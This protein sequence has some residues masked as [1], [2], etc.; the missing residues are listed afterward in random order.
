MQRML[1]TVAVIALVLASLAV[2]ALAAHWPF[3][4]RAWQWQQAAEGWPALA[5]P[6]HTLQPAAAP[7]ALRLAADARLAPP[8]GDAATRMVLV[9]DVGGRAAYW[10]APGYDVHALVD[11]RDLAPSVLAP[12]FGALE[13]RHSTPSLDAPLRVLLEQ[14]AEDPRGDITP[15]QLLW[16]M[17][18]LDAGQL[19]PL[20][21]FS[22]RAQLASGPDF[23]RAALDTPLAWPPG[24]HFEP[25]PA[26]A[27]LLSIAAG[28]LD[29]AGYAH[30]LQQH[31]WGRFAEHPAVGLLDHRR[32]NLAA[33]CCLQAAPVDWLRLGL[34]LAADGRVGADRILPE[35]YVAQMTIASP[36]HPAYGLGYRLAETSGVV[37]LSTGTSGRR[38]AIALQTGRAA[39]WVGEGEP[40][41]WFEALLSPGIFGIADNGPGG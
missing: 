1:V 21:P 13:Q 39:L 11:A 41:A 12:L 36:V 20:N 35:G 7:L 29:G 2:G 27:Q 15:R 5:G 8:D 4:Q 3:W 14:W 9:G 22:T 10:A 33:H 32:G 38:L 25:T 16:E 17:S 26:N 30:A 18:G 23:N 6:T 34:L 28:A 24:S 40:P 37:T 19:R 31:L